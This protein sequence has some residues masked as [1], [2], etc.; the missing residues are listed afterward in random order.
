MEKYKSDVLVK[1]G[2]EIT[3]EEISEDKNKMIISTKN[4]KPHNFSS[5]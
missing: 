5:L 4:L 2:S 3:C 1:K